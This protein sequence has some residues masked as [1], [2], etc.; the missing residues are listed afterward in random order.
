MAV[1]PILVVLVVGVIIFAIC[2]NTGKSEK[3]ENEG[4]KNTDIVKITESNL[5]SENNNFGGF[6]EN[7]DKM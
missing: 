6:S 1:G 2:K 7:Q 3:K 4:E 5:T